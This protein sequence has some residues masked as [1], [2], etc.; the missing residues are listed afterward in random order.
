MDKDKA[1]LVEKIKTEVADIHSK[2]EKSEPEPEVEAQG[3]P[4][5]EPEPEPEVTAEAN[6][7]PE[8]EPE[9]EKS[10]PEA[11]ADPDEPAPEVAAEPDEPAPETAVE[12]EKPVPEAATEPEPE[13]ERPSD[14]FGE[15]PKNAPQKTKERFEAMRKGYDDLSDRYD[16]MKSERE[17]FD[18][19]LSAVFA[20]VPQDVA[21]QQF[22][23]MM[24]HLQNVN[25]GTR[26]G[27][28]RAYDVMSKELQVIGKALGREVPGYDPLEE[29]PDLK[30][31]YENG[32]ISKERALELA[33]VRASRNLERGTQARQDERSHA[34]RAHEKGINSLR[35][36]GTEMR[37]SDPLYDAKLPYLQTAMEAIINSGTDPAKWV[38]SIQEAYK[39]IQLPKPPP[40]P[41]APNPVRPSGSPGA[42]MQREPQTALEA[43]LQG[44]KDF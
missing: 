27:L 32:E 15:L 30:E 44:L 39:K 12:A 3:E 42:R 41:A 7:D 26:D 6:P 34:Q 36:F 43:V 25:S 5:P 35:Q 9:P 17:A 2:E 8:P 38:A 23:L 13:P 24:D 16:K 11:A 37:K 21:T 28:E 14:E 31:E 10:A 40:P 20:N 1:E 18:N 19:Q 29:F 33:G 22:S 4:E